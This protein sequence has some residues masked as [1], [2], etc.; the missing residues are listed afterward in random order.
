MIFFSNIIH[1]PPNSLKAKSYQR[2]ACTGYTLIE[3]L[4]AITIIVFA[5]VG[6]L[7][8]AG[9]S[10]GESYYARDQITAFYLAQEGIEM[11]RA[12]RDTKGSTWLTNVSRTYE[13]DRCT[14]S[15]KVCDIDA[16]ALVTFRIVDCTGANINGIPAAKCAPLMQY[17]TNPSPATIEEGLVYTPDSTLPETTSRT[18]SAVQSKFSRNITIR[19]TANNGKEHTVTVIVWWKNG[20]NTRQV[21]IAESL[22]T[23]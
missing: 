17:P 8:L 5:T 15:T 19:P 2:E 18:G 22:F 4:V 10:L 16:T 6:P 7:E 21:T 23:P 14:G 13:I 3:A 9:K 11:I 1:S 20:L 12:M